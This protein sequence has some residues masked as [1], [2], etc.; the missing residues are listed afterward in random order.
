MIIGFNSYNKSIDFYMIEVPN[1]RILESKKD[2]VIED[3]EKSD[4]KDIIILSILGIFLI[5]IGSFIV[6]K[7]RDFM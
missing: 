1:I 5:L 4:K 7:K 2:K 3:K 6:I